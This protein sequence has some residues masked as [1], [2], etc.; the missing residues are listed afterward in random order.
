MKNHDTTPQSDSAGEGFA[1]TF[2]AIIAVAFAAA[3]TVAG[4]LCVPTAMATPGQ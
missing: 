1:Y 4:L 2:R 3:L